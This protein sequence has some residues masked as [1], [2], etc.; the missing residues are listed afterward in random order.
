MGR[1]T[2]TETPKTP[3]PPTALNPTSTTKTLTRKENERALEHFYTIF[4]HDDTSPLKISLQRAGLKYI[5]HL[6]AMDPSQ[7][8]GLTYPASTTDAIGQTVTKESEVPQFYRAHIKILQGYESYRRDI[9]DP[10]MFDYMSITE[11]NIN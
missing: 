4:N 8:D 9:C 2:K 10:L 5:T 7:I 6:I 3:T 1:T 11:D